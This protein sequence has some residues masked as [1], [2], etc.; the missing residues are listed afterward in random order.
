MKITML[1]FTIGAGIFLNVTNAHAFPGESNKMRPALKGK[2]IFQRAILDHGDKKTPGNE[3]ENAQLYQ[4]DFA[5]NALENISESW[6]LRNAINPHF[7]PDGQSVTFSAISRSQGGL[8]EERDVFFWDLDKKHAPVN[9]TP[10]ND[11]RDEDAKY[12]PDGQAIIFKQNRQIAFLFKQ[13]HATG[14]EVRPVQIGDDE[15]Q[16]IERS[17]PTV[18]PDGEH[19]VFWEGSDPHGLDFD[20]YFSNLDGTQRQPMATTEKL[21][22]YYP[23]PWTENR[24]LYS[25][26]Y[27]S[28]NPNDQI[29]S[30]NMESKQSTRLNFNRE[31]ANYSDAC[32]V[33]DRLVIF[34]SNIANKR[35]GYRLYMADVLTG[36]IWPL[37]A[38]NP[39]IFGGS[40]QQE[41]GATYSSR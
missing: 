20:I 4:Y 37:S 3:K 7:S 14:F 27:S 36:D 28:D 32:P 6:Q 26:W 39:K 19:I 35:E 38:Y 22:E 30:Y 41:L 40:N 5:T 17:G 12:T 11:K 29:Y 8:P 21:S 10:G 23:M 18:A 13:P 33:N 2:L 34:S 15:T 16:S 31:E 24:V 1:A 25:R 9:L